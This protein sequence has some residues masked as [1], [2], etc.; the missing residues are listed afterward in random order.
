MTP[1]IDLEISRRTLSVTLTHGAHLGAVPGSSQLLS[2]LDHVPGSVVRGAYAAAW[3][4]AHGVPSQASRTLRQEFVDL[5]EG[6]VRFGPL[7]AGAPVVPLS[8][9]EHKY[10]A[11]DR[12]PS[13]EY[14]LAGE[15]PSTRCGCR[16]TQARGLRREDKPKM[17]TRMGLEV[18]ED[19]I[20]AEGQLYLH[21]ELRT[22]RL[23]GQVTGPADLLD[24]LGALRG[25][26]LGGNRSTHGGAET[27]WHITTD[28]PVDLVERRDGGRTVVLRFSTPAILVDPLGRPVRQPDPQEIGEV[29]ETK[30]RVRRGWSRWDRVGGWH[31]ASG[32][33][34]PAELC[35]AAGSTYVLD[36]ES[37]VSDE[38]A[39]RLALRGIGLRRHEGFGH[40]TG[41][42]RLA[43]TPQ[44]LLTRYLDTLSGRGVSDPVWTGA[45]KPA[46][47]GDP[48]ARHRMEGVL[49]KM[50]P[51]LRDAVR[52][53]LDGDDE[54]TTKLIGDVDRSR[55][56]A[57][58]TSGGSVA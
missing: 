25:I 17:V 37:P 51:A 10:P 13:E 50:P 6:G 32:L 4:R 18:T 44:V 14:D 38:A 58:A 9:L 12:C 21:E 16:L 53:L 2:S 30:L 39:R 52:F 24:R 23:S 15:D 33:P 8:V 29:V 54:E 56:R 34:K 46:A 43:R 48:A 40:L 26:R 28:D 31:A 5:F 27:A 19:G 1:T 22:R 42:P 45:I 41:R 3:I 11:K 35:V 57:G 20:A 47:T 36:A 49:G 55:N 7:L